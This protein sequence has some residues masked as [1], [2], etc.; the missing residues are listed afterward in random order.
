M[1]WDG[2]GSG[3]GHDRGCGGVME[4]VVD[5]TGWVT[6]VGVVGTDNGSSWGSGY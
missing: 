1:V 5:I 3:G 4:V 2:G 6:V